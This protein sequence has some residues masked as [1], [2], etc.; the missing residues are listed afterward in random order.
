MELWVR[1]ILIIAVLV[2][3]VLAYGKLLMEHKEQEIMICESNHRYDEK[4]VAL[5]VI[6]ARNKLKNR[7]TNIDTMVHYLEA[8]GIEAKFEYCDGV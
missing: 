4:K 6:V 3:S 7:G 1:V 8:N 2:I 5:E